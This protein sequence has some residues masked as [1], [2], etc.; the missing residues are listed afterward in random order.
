MDDSAERVTVDTDRVIAGVDGSASSIAALRYAARVAA[1]FDAPL[2]AVTTWAFPRLAD[3]Y[4]VAAWSPED[5]AAAVLKAAIEQAFGSEP[6]AGLV[7]TVLPG[8]PARTL[9]QLSRNAGM[10]VLGS[11]GRGGF[12]GLLLGSV[13]T[14][15]AAHAH[16]PVLIV[17]GEGADPGDGEPEEESR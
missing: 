17:H 7:G 12:A 1:A 10:L 4:T 11:R 14:A 15:C 5:D 13:S 3:A 8:P 9:V 16:C 2:E 6:P